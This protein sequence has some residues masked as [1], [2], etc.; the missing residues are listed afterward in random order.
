ML[1]ADFRQ[2]ILSGT[3]S[4]NGKA[5]SI[6]ISFSGQA[7]GLRLGAA[8]D[9]VHLPGCLGDGRE[10][11]L[12]TL[13]ES[14]GCH[15]VPLILF[16]RRKR[17]KCVFPG[18]NP[19][20]MGGH[21][22]AARA[23]CRH[24]AGKSTNAPL[25]GGPQPHQDLQVCDYRNLCLSSLPHTASTSHILPQASPCLAAPCTLHTEGK[26]SQQQMMNIWVKGA[27]HEVVCPE[28]R[29]RLH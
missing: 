21:H 4:R 5:S 24:V 2:L 15:Q 28:L 3:A 23:C 19:L 14:P 22:R 16:P 20:H 6:G 7:G 25:P 18:P 17:G 27:K 11:G 29:Q 10:A 9:G 1:P 8:T 12:S 13:P 26:L